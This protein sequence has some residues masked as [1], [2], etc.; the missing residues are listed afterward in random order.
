M[1]TAD[2]IAE[3]IPLF[4]AETTFAHWGTAQASIAFLAGF[5]D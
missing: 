5:D 1:A 4:V 2:G 3:R